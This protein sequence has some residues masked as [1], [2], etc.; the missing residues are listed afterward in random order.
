MGVCMSTVVMDFS[1]A[2]N[3]ESECCQVTSTSYEHLV[4]RLNIASSYLLSRITHEKTLDFF[5]EYVLD[6]LSPIGIEVWS[7]SAFDQPTQVTS[8]YYTN[9]LPVKTSQFTH[10]LGEVAMSGELIVKSLENDISLL[11]VPTHRLCQDNGA[12]IVATSGNLT[13]FPG[14]RLFLQCC[15]ALL[16][17]A[18][19]TEFVSSTEDSE[20]IRNSPLTS[21]QKVIM[22][23]IMDGLTY[24]AIAHKIGFSTSTIK[25]EAKKIFRKLGARS[26]NA[27]VEIMMNGANY[28]DE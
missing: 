25:Q 20:D 24:D 11:V 13:V 5:Y 18:Y 6:F 9:H 23:L 7:F 21:R 16:I 10:E 17:K 3:H 14:L 2:I 12:L 8:T 4:G 15:A 28:F 22:D 27:A 26:R 1:G 19:A